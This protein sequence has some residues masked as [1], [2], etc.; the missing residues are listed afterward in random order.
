M[1]DS[2]IGFI[3]IIAL[4]V[5]L[6]G[7]RAKILAILIGFSS[8]ILAPGIFAQDKPVTVR[9]GYFPNIT[10]AQALVGK[11][12]GRFEKALG[13]GAQVEWKAFNAGPSVIEALFA[14]AIDIAYAGPN[15]TITGYIHSGGQ[16][17][18]VIAGSC[19]GGAAL[20]IRSDS[21]I[22][23]PEDFHGKKI[24]SPQYGNT[25][26]VA[27]RSWLRAHDLK[28]QDK[29]GDVQVVP[30]S[31]ADQYALFV[32]KDLDAS[33]APEPWATRL[34]H[35]G[36]G[37]IF[38]DERDLWPNHRFAT[39]QLVVRTVF[40]Q[41]HPDIVKKWIAEHVDL[42]NWINANLAQSKQLINQ[43]IQK[44]TSKALPKEVLDEA[45]SRLQITYDP[46]RE[47]LLTSAKSAYDLGFLGHQSIDLSGLYRLDILNEVL[48]E[49][50][51]KPVQ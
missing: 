18:R 22:Q 32:K 48:R 27:L 38:L 7:I 9:I 20:V 45:F 31:N 12:T 8:T 17:L 28:T 13:S 15:P 19:S 41:Q 6:T 49:K 10:H 50:K 16:A 5:G 1:V 21:G 39:T 33:W 36:N 51:A 42:T 37:R 14:G 29:G 46:L 44:D 35:E 34:I 25:Q 11:T 23:K 40:L 47:S 2:L 43:Q 30:I 4:A 26:D 3:I 24:G